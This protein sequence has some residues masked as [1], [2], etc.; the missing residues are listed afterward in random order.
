MRRIRIVVACAVTSWAIALARLWPQAN[1]AARP[2]HGANRHVHSRPIRVDEGLLRTD[3]FAQMCVQP[4][5]YQGLGCDLDFFDDLLPRFETQRAPFSI[6]DCALRAPRPPDDS[7]IVRLRDEC[8]E[9]FVI[10]SALD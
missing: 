1:L 9:E 4:F 5:A 10:A 8:A 6:L 3:G 7:R 2:A